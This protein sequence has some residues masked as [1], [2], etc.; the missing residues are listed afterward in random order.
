MLMKCLNE[1]K[2]GEILKNSKGFTL[3]EL[4]MV[5]VLLGVLAAVAIP[6]YIDLQTSAEEATMRAI[7]GNVQSTYTI[8]LASL[9]RA[10]SPGEVNANLTGDLG[11]L[12]MNGSATP[13]LASGGNTILGTKK[14]G[15]F[16]VTLSGAS[17]D[18][19]GNLTIN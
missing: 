6:K 9:R 14:T 17:I 5:I 19:I 18:S 7:Y 8:T 4:V 13:N 15:T 1:T 10:P 3:I 16:T 11:A 2:K 12:T